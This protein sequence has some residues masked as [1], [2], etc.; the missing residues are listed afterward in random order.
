MAARWGRE[1]GPAADVVRRRRRRLDAG[2]APVD[3]QIKAAGG[4]RSGT[5]GIKGEGE[6]GVTQRAPSATSGIRG[7]WQR[8]SGGRRP[9]TNDA[10]DNSGCGERK[11][12]GDYSSGP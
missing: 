8:T 10:G 9:N 6:G 11:E 5:K 12:N 1:G 2:T 3:A 4:A 7:R